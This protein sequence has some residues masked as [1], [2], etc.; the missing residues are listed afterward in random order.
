VH[1][2]TKEVTASQTN[3]LEYITINQPV[4]L[5]EI[6]DCQHMSLPNTS[7]EVKKLTEK[8]L[9]EK[10][11]DTNDRRKQSIKLSI[12]GQA[13]MN[14]SFSEIE[15]RF[16]ERMQPISKEELERIETAIDILHNKVFY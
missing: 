10:I 4:T 15:Q 1:Y 8:K 6:S 11:E 2:L 13:M 16:L 5:S 9:I 7:R 14:Q 3:I 12:E